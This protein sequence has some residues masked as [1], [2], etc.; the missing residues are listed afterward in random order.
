ML[1]RDCSGGIVFNGDAVLLLCNDKH[2]WCF[3]KGAIHSDEKAE[4]VALERVSSEAGI[5]GLILC[6]AGRTNYEFYSISRQRPICNRIVWYVMKALNTNVV[7]NTTQNFRIG[8]FYPIQE[9]LELVTYSQDKSLLML[10]YQRYK[11]LV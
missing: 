11:E 1:M 8:S 5:E 10:A 7:P 9:A 3:P 2:E 4:E 6:P